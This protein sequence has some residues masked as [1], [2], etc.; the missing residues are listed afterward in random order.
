MAVKTCVILLITIGLLVG[1][2][3]ADSSFKPTNVLNSIESNNTQINT[4]AID[5]ESVRA[6]MLN[7]PLSFIENR[8]Q[9]SNDVKFMVKTS[10]ET[11]YFA[12]SNVLFALSSKNNASIVR[13]SFEGANPGQL[14]GEG[15]LP[16]TAN[17][18][19]GNNSSK[20]ITDIPT[21]GSVKYESLYPGVDL[22]FKGTEGNLKHVLLLKP[23]VDPTKIV[24]AYS[25]QDSLNLDKNGSILI[26]TA[27]GDLTD[28]APFCYQDVNGSRMIV[29]GKYR[30]IDDKKIGF[31]INN[32][33]KSLPLVIDPLLRYSTYLGGAEDDKGNGIAVDGYGN[34]YVTGS[35]FSSDFPIKNAYQSNN[36]GNFDAFITKLSHGGASL[37]YSTYL[38]GGKD[39]YGMGIAVDRSN[40][41]YV[42]GTTNSTDFPTEKPFQAANAGGNDTIVV[43]LSP[44]GNKLVYSTYL[45]GAKDDEGWGIAVSNGNNAYVTGRTNSTDFP[46]KN[47]YQAANAGENDTFVTKLGPGGMSLIYS[48]YLGGSDDDG[49]TGIALDRSDNAYVTGETGS[50]NFPTRNAYQKKNA[51][52]LDAFVAKLNSA[53][54]TLFYSTYLGGS[55]LDDG[56]GIAVDRSYNVYVTGWTYSDNFPTEN[57]LQ[58]ANAGHD[59]A[60]VTKLN[61]TGRKLV[62]STYLGGSE[63][64]EGQRIAVDHSD[65]TYVAGA[66]SST[67]FRTKNAYQKT[68]GGGCDDAFVAKLSPAGNNL[69]Y[70]TYLGGNGFDWGSDVAVDGS[71][72]VYVTGCTFSTNF[73]TGN[74]Y[75]DRNAGGNDAFI[76][77][78]TKA[79]PDTPS[80]PSGPVSDKTGFFYRYST[81]ATDPDGYPIKYTFDWGD[82]TKT[83]TRL[84]NSGTEATVAHRWTKVGTFRVAAMATDSKGAT[85]GYSSALEVDISSR[86]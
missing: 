6:E 55:E 14:A 13:M 25:G 29:E 1:P 40:S 3:L 46:T 66:T 16:G 73:P 8:G 5:N 81:S 42:T 62:Y 52:G 82:G 43:K 50:T 39:D 17:F 65:N 86:R 77:D 32:Y 34:A 4:S 75:Q 51:G 22:V 69:V 49:G 64:D 41:A 9:T 63:Y 44:T 23:G 48:T 71:D 60:F 67:D 19:I 58:A 59:D 79:P 53:G 72:D 21:Y 12:P 74:A 7:L 85:S 28:S 30:R 27:A 2:S 68:Y 20:W 54:K 10:S 84:F 36:G 18:F 26:K 56:M 45:G 76:T 35:T 61:P 83:T 80:K 57:P 31:E 33:N 24:L 78:F 15:L 47:A 70:S 37:I 11:I 38:G